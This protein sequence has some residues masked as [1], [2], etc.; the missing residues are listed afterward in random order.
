MKISL[1]K[2]QTS[3]LQR[4]NFP[5]VVAP[6]GA[7]KHRERVKTEIF[8]ATETAEGTQGKI[9]PENRLQK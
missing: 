5:P 9:T 1:D 7:H 4:N 2:L 6:Q 8:W 3:E